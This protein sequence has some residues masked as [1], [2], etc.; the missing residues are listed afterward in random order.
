MRPNPSFPPH[1]ES[2]SSRQADA[3]SSPGTVLYKTVQQLWGRG[4]TLTASPTHIR[5]TRLAALGQPGA[6]TSPHVLPVHQFSHDSHQQEE[7]LPPFPVPSSPPSPKKGP[8]MHKQSWSCAGWPNAGCT[9][10]R[11][12]T[13]HRGKSQARAA[14]VTCRMDGSKEW[15][16]RGHLYLQPSLQHLQEPPPPNQDKPA[17][18]PLVSNCIQACPREQARVE[19]SLHSLLKPPA[20][21]QPFIMVPTAPAGSRN[22]P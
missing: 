14:A 18:L 4:S 8:Q 17:P 20:R 12:L 10:A 3:G 5:P 13:E 19:F 15:R 7:L 1:R 16:A 21:E 11:N 6:R 22:S 2:H 9:A